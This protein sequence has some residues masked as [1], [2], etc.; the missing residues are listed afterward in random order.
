MGILV[1]RAFAN[2]TRRVTYTSSNHR[3]CNFKFVL[4]IFDR[5]IITSTTKETFPLV[6]E[7]YS[8]EKR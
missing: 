6:F 1:A 2:S 4:V 5:V 7:V 3:L 8:W